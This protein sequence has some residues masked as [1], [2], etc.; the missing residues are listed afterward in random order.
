MKLR[1]QLRVRHPFFP[2]LSI[3]PAA[4]AKGRCTAISGTFRQ[5]EKASLRGVRVQRAVFAL[6]LKGAPFLSDAER[7]RLWQIFEVPVYGLLLNRKRKLLAYECEAQNGLHIAASAS[8]LQ[9]S[10]CDCGRPG[11]RIQK[12]PA[13]APLAIPAAWP[14][15]A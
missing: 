15:T 9:Y 2:A 14:L 7:D 10:P 13:L 8:E 1:I 3:T 5:L 4:E 12:G 6:N 11:S